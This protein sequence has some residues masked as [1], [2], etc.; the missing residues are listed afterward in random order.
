MKLFFCPSCARVYFLSEESH[1]LCGRNHAPA[2]WPDGKVRRFVI[3]NQSETNKP[4]WPIPELSEE[5][6]LL[7]QEY[8]E[9]W[10]T[11]CEHPEDIDYGD[12]RRHFG[13]GAPGGRHLTREQLIEKYSLFVLKQVET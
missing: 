3:T 4:P 9:S 5:Q 11:A 8:T 13:Y 12:V 1:Y 7:Q 10:L 6:D 2:T